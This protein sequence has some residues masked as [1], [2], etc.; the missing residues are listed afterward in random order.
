MDWLSLLLLA[1][2]GAMAYL[3]TIHGMVSAV[4][5]CVLVLICV[6]TA[7]ATFEW[8]AYSWLSEP[9][10]DLAPP[11]ALMATFLLPF[12]VLRVALDALITRSNLLPVVLD[13]SVAAV[14]GFLGA[15]LSI[16]LLAMAIQMVPFGGSFLGTARFDR[17][18]GEETD[19]WLGP[20]R[21]AA[22]FA[23]MMTR[24]VFSGDRRWEDIHPDLIT[25][26]RWSTAVDRHVRTVAPPGTVRLVKVELPRYIFDK[27]PASGRGTNL[28]PASYNPVSAPVGR[29]WFLIR[30]A[31]GEESRD[32]DERHR[33]TRRQAWLAGYPRDGASLARYLPVAITDSDDTTRHCRINDRDLYRPGD[34][35]EI[36]FVFEVEDEFRPLFLSY[37]SGARVDLAKV[38]L[39]PEQAPAVASTSPVAPAPPAPPSTPAPAGSPPPADRGSGDRVSGARGLEGR[40]N[41]T[42][43]RMTDFQSL[44]LEQT[45]DAISNGHI[46]GDSAKQG[47]SSSGTTVARFVVPADKRMFQLEVTVLRASSTLGHALSF[48]VTTLR[49]YQLQ[50]AEGRSYSVVGQIATADVDGTEVIE[51]EYYPSTVEIANRGGMRAFQRI[52]DRHLDGPNYHLVYVFLVE[53]GSTITEFRTGQGRHPTDLR[54]LNLVAPR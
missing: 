9:L 39:K 33:F 15:Y 8:V 12:I 38:D 41:D 19:L 22:G 2:M 10:G 46:W 1:A 53:P 4:I 42:L 52:K 5:N 7:V 37:K 14:A 17:E 28:V 16:G 44:D 24:G 40:F 20:D 25:E 54:H 48:A 23:G 27:T 47:G 26:I 49:N 13:R 36:D 29:Q 50:D 3:Q 6:P 21:F 34:N 30:V 18:K 45:G 32:A 31:V 43:P 51:V 35:D 11:V